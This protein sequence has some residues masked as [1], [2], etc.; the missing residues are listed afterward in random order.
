M[1]L[2][3]QTI[4]KAPLEDVF[5][6]FSAPE[7]LA[8]L[9]PR[10]LGFR[11]ISAPHRPLRKGDR[12]TYRIRI[13]GIPVRWVTLITDWVPND[14]FTDTQEKGPYE[15][16]VHSHR[17]AKVAE[18]VLMEDRV[19][20]ELPFGKLGKVAGGGFVRWQLRRIFDFRTR[21]IRSIFET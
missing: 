21:V 19:D 9:T 7:N 11:I 2:Q 14:S 15:K 1:L 17:F 12:I 10:S 20:Y 5:A 18:G 8:R 13:A 3:Q 16:W 4:I 6:F